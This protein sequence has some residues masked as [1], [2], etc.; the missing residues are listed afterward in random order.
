M[1]T[2]L[3]QE[4]LRF[5]RLTGTVRS[6]LRDL[7]RALRGQLLLSAELED[8]FNSIIMGKVQ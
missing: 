6:S 8:M 2:V 3:V 7:G 1:N 5:S 4:L